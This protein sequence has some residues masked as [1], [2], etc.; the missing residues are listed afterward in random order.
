M[1]K[2]Q[3]ELIEMRHGLHIGRNWL[4]PNV[5]VPLSEEAIDELQVELDLLAQRMLELKNQLHECTKAPLLRRR[6]IVN[7]YE[8]SL[9]DS[10][11]DIIVQT[12]HLFISESAK[13][14]ADWILNHLTD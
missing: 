9:D 4:M 13:E 14:T 11:W 1:N 8:V 2:E 3:R 5:T 7:N 6:T 12:K 10:K